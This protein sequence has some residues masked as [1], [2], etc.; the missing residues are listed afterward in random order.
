MK[1]VR[2]TKMVEVTEVKFVAE[3]GKEFTGPRAEQECRWHER[4]KNKNEIEKSYN[5]MNPIILKTPY[6]T[7]FCDDYQLCKVVLH[8]K[9]D[10]MTLIDYFEVVCGIDMVNIEEP[11]VYPHTMIISTSEF[12]ADEYSNDLKDELQKTLEQLN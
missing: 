10:Y 3:D 5:R 12:C 11:P 6:I 1:E 8:S 4:L 9:I 7:W 2:T